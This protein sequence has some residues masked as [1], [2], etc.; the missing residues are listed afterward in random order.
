L[1]HRDPETQVNVFVFRETP[2][3]NEMIYSG[4]VLTDRIERKV[5]NILAYNNETVYKTTYIA[6]GNS[7]VAQTLTKLDTEATSTGFERA[8][9]TTTAW[10][11]SGDWAANFTHKFTATGNIVINATALH[12][13][14][15][16]GATNA[17]AIASLGASY[18]FQNNWN[19]TIV[20]S[21]THNWN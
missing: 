12:E 5:R 10:V 2:E 11:N 4:N 21:I 16:A 14:V 19:C 15:T 18:S 13:T 3:G 20:W 8:N 17:V 9:S 1:K 6:L 7:T